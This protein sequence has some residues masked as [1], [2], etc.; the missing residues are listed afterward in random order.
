MSHEQES[1]HRA[2]NGMPVGW[3]LSTNL[4]P[5]ECGPVTGF[6]G[7]TST[8]LEAYRRRS[9]LGS[10]GKAGGARPGSGASGIARYRG[11]AHLQYHLWME[12][13]ESKD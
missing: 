6:A 7:E 9:K 12:P 2:P 11:H 5:D 4:S 3:V 8:P 13:A 10:L 1:H